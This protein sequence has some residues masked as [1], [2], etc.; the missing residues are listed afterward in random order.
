MREVRLSF[1]FLSIFLQKNRGIPPHPYSPKG[2]IR[3][4]VPR[5]FNFRLPDPLNYIVRNLSVLDG[6]YKTM[7]YTT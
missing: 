2:Y 6:L 1:N 4:I 7:L 5:L 3:Y